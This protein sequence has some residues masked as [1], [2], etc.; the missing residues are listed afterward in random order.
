M[1]VG[2]VRSSVTWEYADGAGALGTSLL[3]LTGWSETG[4]AQSCASPPGQGSVGK[5]TL[6]L[7]EIAR[8]AG[9]FCFVIWGQDPSEEG[10]EEIVYTHCM[11]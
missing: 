2:P 4:E 9:Q 11:D 8:T 10:R 7:D 6:F 5:H 3:G 1:Q